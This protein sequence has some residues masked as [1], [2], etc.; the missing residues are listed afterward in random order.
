MKNTL[1][2][3]TPERARE[4]AEL[5]LL[6]GEELIPALFGSGAERFWECAF[7]HRRCGFSY[8]HS[9]FLEVDGKLAGIAV[10]YDYGTRKKEKFRTFLIILRCLR[11]AFLRQMAELRQSGD[12]MARTKEGDYYLSNLA[13]YPQYRGQGYGTVI[14]DL[15]EKMA[16]KAGCH[17][18]VLDAEDSKDQTIQFYKRRGYEI[19]EALPVLKTKMGDFGLYRMVKVLGQE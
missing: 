14:M 12:I 15:V 4:G 7:R 19:E 3:A 6:A 2:I 8:E 1:T 13:V 18:M 9:W 16:A 10:G 5:A 17:R 11:W